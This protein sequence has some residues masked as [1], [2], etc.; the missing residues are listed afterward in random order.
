MQQY[1]HHTS[2]QKLPGVLTFIHR[3]ANSWLVVD[4]CYLLVLL[5]SV[6]QTLTF[7]AISV[8]Y[9]RWNT[10]QIFFF[11]FFNSLMS[12]AQS[13]LLWSCIKYKS[14]TDNVIVIY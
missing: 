14:I 1:T 4:K 13:N 3:L 6:L 11:F 5:T 8:L 12:P 7:N 10:A 9:N 2:E